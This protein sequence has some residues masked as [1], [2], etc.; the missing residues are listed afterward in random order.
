MLEYAVSVSGRASFS[1]SE[2]GV[3]LVTLD[4]LRILTRSRHNRMMLLQLGGLPR[5]TRLMKVR[6]S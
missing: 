3:A 5:L 2:A 6:P 4:V 1:E